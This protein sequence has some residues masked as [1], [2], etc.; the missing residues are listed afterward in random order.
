MQLVGLMHGGVGAAAAQAVEAQVV[1]MRYAVLA[2]HDVESGMQTRECSAWVRVGR[3]EFLQRFAEYAVF[4][5]YDG[6]ASVLQFA[7]GVVDVG[8][9]QACWIL[10][11]RMFVCPMR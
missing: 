11:F 2:A 6:L 10:A 9:Y 8:D 4:F 3:A 1:G 5:G 7:K